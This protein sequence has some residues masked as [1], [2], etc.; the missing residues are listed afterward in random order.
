MNSHNTQ[1][2]KTTQGINVL[3][4]HIC[5]N[6]E[7]VLVTIANLGKIIWLSDSFIYLRVMLSRYYHTLKYLRTRQIFYQLYY[8]FR[9]LFRKF[10]GYRPAFNHY[11]KGELLV[12][13]EWIKAHDSYHQNTFTFLNLPVTFEKINWDY[14]LNGKLWTY[15]L[16]YFDFLNQSAI[17]KEEGLSL[18]RNFIPQLPQLKNANEPYPISLRGINWIKFICK[19][20]LQDKDIDQSL[21]SQYR[22]LQQHIEYH[23]LGNHLLENAFSLYIG[24]LYFNDDQ[25]RSKGFKLIS[26]E[27]KEQTLKDGGHFELSPMY[28]QIILT[29]LLDCC[30]FATNKIELETLRNYATKMLAWLRTM[31]LRNGDIPL[32]NDSAKNIAPPSAEIFAYAQRLGISSGAATL[33]DSGYR[34]WDIDGAELIMDVGKV[35]PDYIPGHAHADIFSF[36]LY[37]GGPVITDT[38]ISTYEKNPRREEE[39]G[40]ACHNTVCVNGQN[41]VDTWGG[42]RVGKR[43]KVVIDL[44]QK[45]EIAAHH[46]G[47]AGTIHSRNWK[48]INDIEFLISDELKGKDING[49]FHLHFHPSVK[50]VLENNVLYAANWKI[51]FDKVKTVSLQKYAHAED[52]NILGEGT[53]AKIEFESDI[54]TSVTRVKL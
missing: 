40:T 14:P 25:L 27:L 52:F 30:S 24:G 23:L 18:I 15:N 31:T 41:Q 42:F 16:N 26:E 45:D 48:K 54:T 12:F 51:S 33:S 9:A 38:G 8:K 5:T 20:K 43:C 10:T 53:R 32:L 7:A 19:H 29:R 35:G 39:R 34:K 50:V 17:N 46:N 6:I 21:Y 13:T 49:I 4:F 28:H 3:V 36:V 1:N 22:I 11:K 47:Y 2:G 44:E 37:D